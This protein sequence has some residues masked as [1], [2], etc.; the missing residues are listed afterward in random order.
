MEK[1]FQ[2]LVLS[3][4]LL[5]VDPAVAQVSDCAE[6]GETLVRKV[7]D[8]LVPEASPSEVCRLVRE[9]LS[10]VGVC[11]DPVELTTLRNL[12]DCYCPKERPFSNS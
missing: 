11:A 10:E 6:V 2:G 4:A 9:A 3:S 1:L 5:S 12:Q 7:L 8:R